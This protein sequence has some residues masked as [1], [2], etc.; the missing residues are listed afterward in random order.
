MRS[1]IKC[2]YLYFIL[3]IFL[4][5]LYLFTR[6]FGEQEKF[7]GDLFNQQ[8]HFRLFDDVNFVKNSNEFLILDWTGKQHIFREKDPIKCKFFVYFQKENA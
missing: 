4:F 8:R 7:N 1:T 6:F 2:L 3:G 5:N